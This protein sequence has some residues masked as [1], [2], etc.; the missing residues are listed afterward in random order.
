MATPRD[1]RR[2]ALLAL[3]Q[4]DA[5]RTD[6]IEDIR[7]SLDNLEA[8]EEEGLTFADPNRAFTDA[9]KDKA[10]RIALAAWLDRENA[11][12][13]FAELAPEW[14]AHRMP[15]VDRAVLRLCHH[16]MRAGSPPKAVVN[17]GV[18]LA[19]QFSTKESPN[20]VNALLDKVLKRILAET[21]AARTD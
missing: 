21:P 18:E 13:A 10:V 2:L 14:P 6:S 15:A 11:D 4:F 19:K 12:A 16:E 5:L 9:D 7:G 3:Y 17:E 20:F 1:I 8:L